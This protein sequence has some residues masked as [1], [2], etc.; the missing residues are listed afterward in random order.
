[1]VVDEDRLDFL[2]EESASDVA[3]HHARQPWRVL[4]VDDDEDCLLYTSRCV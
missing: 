2:D 4:I 3:A 1:M